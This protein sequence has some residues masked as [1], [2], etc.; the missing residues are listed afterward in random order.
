MTAPARERVPNGE[1]LLDVRVPNWIK[2]VDPDTLYIGSGTFDVLGQIFGSYWAGVDE[3]FGT[4]STPLERHLLACALGF[5]WQR[6]CA[7]P[8]REVAELTDEWRATVRERRA[9]RA[10]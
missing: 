5:S 10:A 6:D 4:D 3:L 9:G 8:E 1:A 7:D 2:I